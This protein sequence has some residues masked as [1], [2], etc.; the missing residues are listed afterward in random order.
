M[1]AIDAILYGVVQGLTEFLP[2]SS[3]GHLALL[4]RY[5]HIHD[6][7]VAFD[8]AMHVG[9]ALAILIYFRK[10]LLKILSLGQRNFLINQIFATAMSV[11]F[12][13]IFKGL[14]ERFG[15]DPKIIALNLVLFGVLMVIADKKGTMKQTNLMRDK[16][17]YRR[18]FM[19]GMFQAMAVFPGVSRSGATLTIARFVGL[20]RHEAGRFSFLL[21]L[22][23]IF[24]GFLYKLPELSGGADFDLVTILIGI[25][26]SFVVGYATIHYF[27]KF[28]EKIG[29]TV[30]GVYRF[31][32]ALAVY[33][34]F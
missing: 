30:F 29:L 18:S 17:D 1:T 3:S 10:D 24:A 4:P 11:I 31:L 15:R 21:S 20:S 27:L 23:I 22:P 16:T 19:I 13:F 8:L 26:T 25:L 14:S 33:F 7:G 12:I 9:T 28:I 32:L 5:L 6:P 2:V 34:S